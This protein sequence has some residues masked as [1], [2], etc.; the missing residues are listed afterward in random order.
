MGS[1]KLQALQMA[2]HHGGGRESWTLGGP[3]CVMSACANTGAWRT[4]WGKRAAHLLLVDQGHMQ[5][6][7]GVPPLWHCV[8][9]GFA[10]PRAAAAYRCSGISRGV[11]V[12]TQL[13]LCAGRSCSTAARARQHGAGRVSRRVGDEDLRRAAARML[14][15]CVAFCHTPCRAWLHAGTAAQQQMRT[16]LPPRE[17]SRTQR[18]PSA[19]PPKVARTRPGTFSRSHSSSTPA[20]ARAAHPR[21]AGRRG[22]LAGFV[23]TQQGI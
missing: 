15:Y 23:Y 8:R 5:R 6:R 11:R 10:P 1:G 22:T 14:A 7:G 2:P 21:P 9:I 17:R 13:P 19:L 16:I 4:Q 20:P 12:P 18:P 3:A